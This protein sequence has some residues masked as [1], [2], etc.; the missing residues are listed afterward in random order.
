MPSDHNLRTLYCTENPLV[1]FNKWIFEKSNYISLDILSL[2][3]FL[4]QDEV[5]NLKEQT[6]LTF[7]KDDPIVKEFMTAFDKDG[8]EQ[9]RKFISISLY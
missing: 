7:S 2:L 1:F 6:N 5:E 3:R 9:G 8:F 4:R